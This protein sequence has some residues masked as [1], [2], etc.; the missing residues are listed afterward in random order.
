MT[1]A[2]GEL[3]VA[4]SD[5]D[6]APQ[7]RYVEVGAAG[8]TADFQLVPGGVIEGVVRVE[9][10]KQPVAGAEV[11]ARRDAPAM[12]LGEVARR[13]ATA[14]GDGRFR[15]G[16][17]RPG[18][19]ELGAHT[20][21]ATTRAP[22]RVGLGV[23]EQVSNVEILI[24]AGPVVRGTIVDEAGTPVAGSIEIEGQR[25]GRLEDTDKR[26]AFA[27]TGLAPGHYTL[28]GHAD[29]F[30]PA[31]SPDVELAD[32]DVDGVRVVVRR[33]VKIK[34]HVD[35]RQICDVSAETEGVR[36]ASVFEPT[37]TAADGEFTFGPADNGA[38]TLA[39]R[40]PSGDQGS[41]EIHVAPGLAEQIVKVTPGGSIAGHV[42]DGAGK[43]VAGVTVMAAPQDK[44]DRTTIVNGVVT[45]GVQAITTGAGTYEVRGLAAGT[46]DVHAL[47]RGKPLPTKTEAHVALGAAEHKTGIDLSVERADGLIRGTV[48]GADGKP[49]ADAWVSVHQELEDMLASMSPHDTGSHTITIEN[50]DD[51][52]NEAAPA[53]TDAAG[54]FELG[55]LP[56]VPWTVVAEAQAGKLRAR[57]GGVK[58]DATITLQALGVAS[59]S[60]TVHA[61]GPITSFSVELDG[62]TRAQRGFAN[63]DGTFAFASVDAGAYTVRVT[64][65]A[66]NGEATVTVVGGQPATVDITLASNAVVIGKLVDPSGKPIVGAPVTTVPDAGNG[67]VSVS[68]EGPPPL[69]GADGG[70]RVEGKAGKAALV[71]LRD[72]TF[73]RPGLVLVAGQTL[74]LGTIT[75][76]AGPPHGP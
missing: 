33:G 31:A 55:G 21:S 30:V 70:F 11:E 27:V 8:A 37:T 51:G 34:G 43:P 59:L 32:K 53:L 72:P 50:T 3:L 12:M 1:V 61:P 6:Y 5:P 44:G 4:A 52:A 39:A 13:G 26:G 36:G 76:S 71:V 17:L 16:G 22:T 29:D 75:V 40:C 18:M 19:Y 54:H 23:A 42:V 35:P 9:H 45:S 64:S 14:G 62:P 28:R 24:G 56:R 69:T 65:P 10:T 74:D 25:T 47:D 57:Q 68:L 60:G 2:E 41:L 38:V 20:A 49:L 63:A 46:Y 58:P 7:S 67:K 15:I 66:G 73:V 48:T